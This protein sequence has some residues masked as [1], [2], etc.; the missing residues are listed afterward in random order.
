MNFVVR[1]WSHPVTSHYLYIN[2]AKWSEFSNISGPRHLRKR[3]AC[4]LCHFGWYQSRTLWQACGKVSMAI[5]SIFF[6]TEEA[7][8]I[9]GLQTCWESSLL[10]FT[11]PYTA[12]SICTSVLPLRLCFVI[13]CERI[14]KDSSWAVLL[15]VSQASKSLGKFEKTEFCPSHSELH[16]QNLHLP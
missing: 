14:S 15:H 12:P 1:L 11:T 6:C 16:M 4:S 3:H 10:P 7:W 2:V 5:C 13:W 8:A 9:V